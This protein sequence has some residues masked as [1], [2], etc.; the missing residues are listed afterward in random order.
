[1]ISFLVPCLSSC[2]DP[3]AAQIA[4]KKSLIFRMHTDTGAGN[5]KSGIE[6]RQV[7]QGT[8]K[9]GRVK[10]G[11]TGSIMQFGNTRWSGKWVIQ[12]LGFK[13]YCLIVGVAPVVRSKKTLV[14]G[15]QIR[16]LNRQKL[17][18]VRSIQGCGINGEKRK[19]PRRLA[20]NRGR[21]RLV[22]AAGASY[23][24]AWCRCGNG[25]LK[26]TNYW[27]AAVTA[28]QLLCFARWKKPRLHPKCI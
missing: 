25:E 21:C 2:Q 5:L 6:G 15:R 3:S 11:Q 22:E 7:Y 13:Y 18:Q 12:S 17:Q 26:N 20:S 1:M 23:L 19:N 10:H 9:A 16:Q 14:A 4:G 27:L 28:A 24:E 8:T